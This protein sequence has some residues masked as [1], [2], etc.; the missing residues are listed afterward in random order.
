MSEVKDLV[1]NIENA[2]IFQDREV[3]SDVNLKVEKGEFIYLI[4]KTGSG[5]SSLLKT[6]YADLPLMDGKMEVCGYDIGNLKKKN[7]PMLRRKLG[8]IFQDF[9]LLQDRNVYENV[10]FVLR[11]TG[12]KDKS[13]IALK[14]GKALDDVGLSDKANANI[15]SLSEGEMQR[16]NIARAIVNSPELII[17]DEPTGNLDPITAEEITELLQKISEDHKTTVIMATHNFLVIEKFR[18]RVICTEDGRLID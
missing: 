13:Q 7:V 17:A 18:K 8:I 9:Q 6:L 16:V 3:L 2:K 1:I 14:V 11:S 5:K 10:A 4:G 15:F 12:V